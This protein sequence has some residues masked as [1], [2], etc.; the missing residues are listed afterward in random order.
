MQQ[1][2]R[3]NGIPTDGSWSSDDQAMA[4]EIWQEMVVGFRWTPVLKMW[5]EGKIVLST[6][7]CLAEIDVFLLQ[8]YIF[9]VRVEIIYPISGTVHNM[10]SSSGHFIGK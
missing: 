4:L 10:A 7:I 5:Q 9:S 8:N 6:R 3:C 2:N 1:Q